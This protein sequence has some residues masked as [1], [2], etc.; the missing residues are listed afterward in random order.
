MRIRKIVVALLLILCVAGAVFGFFQ[1]QR[2]IKIKNVKS[3]EEC[4]TFSE[5]LNSYPPR[6][7]TPDGRTFTQSV[8][9]E[10]EM[11][12]EIIVTTPRPNQALSSPIII[13]GRARGSWFFE[14]SLSGELV[15]GNNKKIGSAI[16][17]AEGEWMTDE[18]VHFKGDLKFNKPENGGGTLFIHKANPSGLPEN[19]KKLT[20]PVKF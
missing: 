2:H 9:N 12:D 3:F 20:I 1:Y 8:G 18:F 7:N 16:L 4:V 10:L 15:D 11:L 5:T 14:G 19:N 6:C 17:T 13:E